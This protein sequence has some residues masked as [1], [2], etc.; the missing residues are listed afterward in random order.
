MKSPCV[1]DGGD[2][3][4]FATAGGAHFFDARHFGGEAHSARALN[5][6]LV[7]FSLDQRAQMLFSTARLFS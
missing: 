6:A 3:H 7:H 2:F 4:I 5:A 1:R